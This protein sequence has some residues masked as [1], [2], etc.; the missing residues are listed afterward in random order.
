MSGLPAFAPLQAV[1]AEIFQNEKVKDCKE[2]TIITFS[3]VKLSKCQEEKLCYPCGF[4]PLCVYFLY[5]TDKY[6]CEGC[7]PSSSLQYSECDKYYYEELSCD[8]LADP[9][10]KAACLTGLSKNLRR[11]LECKEKKEKCKKE[12]SERSEH[13]GDSSHSC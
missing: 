13:D 11:F 1:V 4:K 7:H 6:P 5:Q 9:C 3:N 8:G 2:E 12:R 10:A